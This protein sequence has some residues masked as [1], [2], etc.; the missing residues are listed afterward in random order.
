MEKLVLGVDLGGT[1]INTGIVKENGEI[2]N[3]IKVPTIAE[4]GPDAVIGRII[5]S[6]KDVLEKSKVD[7]SDIEGIGIGSPGPIDSKKGVV[8]NPSNLPGWNNVHITDKIYNEFKLPV[9]LEN[10]ANA[11]GFGEYVFGS[12]KGKNPF[13]YITVSTGIGGGVVIDGKILDGINSNGAEI[14]HHMINFDGPNA[15]AETEAVLKHMHP[16]L[17]LQDLLK[18]L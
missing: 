2:V 14:G 17:Q 18:K 1:K 9:K 5:K 8:M 10:D 4:E 11:A 15:D 13:V 7:I 16:V 6:I 3:N 12:G